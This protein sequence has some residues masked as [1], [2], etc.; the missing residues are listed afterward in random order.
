MSTRA[1]YKPANHIGDLEPGSGFQAFD[2]FML[3]DQMRKPVRQAAEAIATDAVEMY[4]TE[5]TQTGELAESVDVVDQ[6]VSINGN[7]RIA[8]AVTAHGGTYPKARDPES[9]KAAI[10]EWGNP[11]GTAYGAAAREGLHIMARAG[12]PYDTPKLVDPA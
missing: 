6:V 4:R 5:A 2:A 12:I 3:S 8:A 7:P 1:R 11:Q 9:S 10:I